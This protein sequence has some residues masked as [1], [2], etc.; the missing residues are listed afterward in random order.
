MLQLRQVWVTSKG[1]LTV[2]VAPSSPSSGCVVSLQNPKQ[3]VEAAWC[4]PCPAAQHPLLLRGQGWLWAE[5]AW[6]GQGG[7]C[8][9]PGKRRVCQQAPMLQ[10]PRSAPWRPADAADPGSTGTGQ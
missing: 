1:H 10:A 4:S 2:W 6:R 9:S 5:Q 3:G 8:A 7:G